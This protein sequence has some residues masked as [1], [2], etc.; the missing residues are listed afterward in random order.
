MAKKTKT[1][2]SP[3]TPK[4]DLPTDTVAAAIQDASHPRHQGAP[5]LIG[6]R[7]ADGKEHVG[8][9]IAAHAGWYVLEPYGT[10]PKKPE[11]VF[12]DRFHI[13]SARIAWRNDA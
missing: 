5:F 4:N 7:T 12:I 13:V 6:I 2:K 3:K 8:S 1:P 10:D 9:V 11:Y